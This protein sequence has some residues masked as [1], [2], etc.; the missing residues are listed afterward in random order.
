VNQREIVWSGE[1]NRRKD[2]FQGVILGSDI[3]RLVVEPS[4]RDRVRGKSLERKANAYVRTP[5]TVE[6][7]LRRGLR[8]DDLAW[9]YQREFISIANA[10]GT[11]IRDDPGRASLAKY[12]SMSNNRD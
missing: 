3:V 10:S 12:W 7:Y 11:E 6:E 8:K 1:M 2:Y 5:L 9:D 4:N